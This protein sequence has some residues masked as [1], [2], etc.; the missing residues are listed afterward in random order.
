M[1]STRLPQIPEPNFGEA[2][3]IGLTARYTDV[4]DMAKKN[5]AL[6]IPVKVGRH[7]SGTV[8]HNQIVGEE[9]PRRRELRAAQRMAVGADRHAKKDERGSG[10]VHPAECGVKA[11]AAVAPQLWQTEEGSCICVRRGS[12]RSC[13]SFVTVL[14]KS[15]ALDLS[16]SYCLAP[17]RGMKPSRIRTLT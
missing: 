9:T 14:S 15:M 12:I 7:T 4:V 16:G 1:A 5:P 17:R 8:G 2:L 3:V 13:G 11:S 6:F 10:V